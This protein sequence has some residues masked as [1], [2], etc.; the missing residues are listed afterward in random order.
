MLNSFIYDAH[1]DKTLIVGLC[2][3]NLGWLLI[4]LYT[5]IMCYYTDIMCYPF[6]KKWEKIIFIIVAIAGTLYMINLDLSCSVI[7]QHIK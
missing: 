7:F 5:Y 2:A 4:M 6:L 1:S 3:G